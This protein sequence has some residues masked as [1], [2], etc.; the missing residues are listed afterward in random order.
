MCAESASC[1]ETQQNHGKLP[2]KS[3]WVGGMTEGR[4]Q[5]EVSREGCG[6]PRKNVSQASTRYEVQIVTIVATGTNKWSTFLLPGG[7]TP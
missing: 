5:E 6:V 2:A 3:E 1:A 7:P 4:F